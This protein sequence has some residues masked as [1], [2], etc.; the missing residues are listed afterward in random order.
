MS[1]P[2]ERAITELNL[3]KDFISAATQNMSDGLFSGASVETRMARDA[4]TQALLEIER[5]IAASE[6][7]VPRENSRCSTRPRVY[8]DKGRV[9]RSY[10]IR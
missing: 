9:H 7:E 3:S 5:A 1:A 10:G 2:T 8:G 6:L 4:I